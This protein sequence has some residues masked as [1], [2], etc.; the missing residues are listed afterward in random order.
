MNYK[1]EIKAIVFDFDGTLIDFDY[2]ASDY[3]RLA[4]EKLKDSKYKICLAS[5]RPCFLAIKAFTNTFGDYPLDYIF[6]CNGSEMM[7]VKN[8][9]INLLSLFK[10]EDVRYLGKELDA[11][12]LVLGIYEGFNFL[13]N[14]EVKDQELKDWCDAR[15]LKPVVYDFS[16]NE[17]DRSK[18]ICLN[19]AKD[20][21]RQIEFVNTKDLSR[22]CAEYSTKNCFEIQSFGVNK[23]KAMDE[24]AKTLGC[25]NK[26]IL[27]FGDMANDLSMLINSTGV[28][29]G[30][31]TEDVKAAVKLRTDDVKNKGVYQFLHDNELI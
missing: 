14:R 21:E 25:D 3:T 23:G 20:R 29:M 7:D 22:F 19:C 4:L 9:E 8:N 12:Y 28:A 11:D 15:W 26:N 16:K 24:L 10:A 17:V 31:A 27:S 5:G 18:V 2:K 1:D 30:N 6:G 13:V